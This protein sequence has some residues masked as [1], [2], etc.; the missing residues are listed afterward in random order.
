MSFRLGIELRPDI[1]RNV[2]IV[3]AFSA[4]CNSAWLQLFTAL[5]ARTSGESPFE[6][7]KETLAQLKAYVS[8]GSRTLRMA[9]INE[10]IPLVLPDI[11]GIAAAAQREEGQLAAKRNILAHQIALTSA[12]QEAPAVWIDYRKLPF[13]ALADASTEVDDGQLVESYRSYTDRLWQLA[14]WTFHR[15]FDEAPVWNPGP[16]LHLPVFPEAGPG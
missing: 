14:T 6:M 1:A 16:V 15:L 4:S 10:L 9:R 2:G 3:V 13:G 5:T 11:A 7:R 12:A 8:I